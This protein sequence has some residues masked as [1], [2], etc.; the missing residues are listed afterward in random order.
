[1]KNLKLEIQKLI[2]KN[3]KIKKIWEQ[4]KK[5]YHSYPFNKYELFFSK[6]ISDKIISFDDYLK[7]RENYKNRN[8]YLHCYNLPPRQFGQNWAE[9]HIKKIFPELLKPTKSKDKNYS[10]GNYDFWFNEQRIEV[11]ASRATN[12]NQFS[13]QSIIKKALS[14][15]DKYLYDFDMNFQQIKP[16]EAD[17]FIF[18]I[19]WKD[20]LDYYLFKSQDI[21][22]N[23]FFNS[24]QHRGNVGEGQLH[25][26]KNNISYFD[27]Y[28]INI[29][30]LLKLIKKI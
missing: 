13:N 26:K 7:I 25:F 21:C 1:M 11:K 27:K 12:K 8:L 9:R 4:N 29:K 5:D 17:W 22:D 14:Y 28:M 20:R 16:K 19:V 30:D 6:I 10:N 15:E 2:K 23:K 3:P 18:I 24:K